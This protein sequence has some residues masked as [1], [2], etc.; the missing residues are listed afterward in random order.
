M[1]LS[2]ETKFSLNRP[3]NRAKILSTEFFEKRFFKNRKFLVAKGLRSLS[4]GS[5]GGKGLG[6]SYQ[7]CDGL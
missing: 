2:N 1:W 5:E 4:C 6:I 7:I 3:L